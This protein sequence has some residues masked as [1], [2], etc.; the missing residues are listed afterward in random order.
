MVYALARRRIT[1]LVLRPLIKRKNADSSNVLPTAGPPRRHLH[2][3][4][5]RNRR[6]RFVIGENMGVDTDGEYDDHIPPGVQSIVSEEAEEGDPN[7]PPILDDIARRPRPSQTVYIT[8]GSFARLS[9]ETLSL[10]FIAS[11]IGQGLSFVAGKMKP[12]NWLQRLLGVHQP[13][14]GQSQRWDAWTTTPQCQSFHWRNTLSLWLYVVGRDSLS[15]VYRYLRLKQ[16]GKASIADL[17]F[18]DNI[19]LS[20][21]LK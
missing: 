4:R 14:R 5:I 18:D 10:P 7:Q 6:L 19:A 13:P 20:F 8:L 1:R 16:R 17:P 3:G 12:G 2:M 11:A 15:L 9:L 21:E